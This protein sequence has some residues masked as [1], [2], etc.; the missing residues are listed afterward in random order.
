ML[1]YRSLLNSGLCGIIVVRTWALIIRIE[2]GRWARKNNMI[3]WMTNVPCN[4]DWCFYMLH[5][6]SFFILMVFFLKWIVSCS[7][8]E[9][10][11]LAIRNRSHFAS[12]RTKGLFIVYFFRTRTH[13][14]AY[15]VPFF[16]RFRIL[17][18]ISVVYFVFSISIWYF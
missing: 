6:M 18:N 4:A 5:G 10:L 11:F 3:M 9:Q 15:L 16:Y 12:I 2:N 14:L 7:F 8:R 1:N 17:G 13:F